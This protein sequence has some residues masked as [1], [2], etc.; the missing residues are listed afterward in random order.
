[1]MSLC[2]FVC[3]KTKARGSLWTKTRFGKLALKYMPVFF[4]PMRSTAED[5]TYASTSHSPIADPSP[6][7]TEVT[8]LMRTRF[9]CGLSSSVAKKY[10]PPDTLFGVPDAVDPAVTWAFRKS[11]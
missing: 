6:P 4:G 11:R 10:D 7:L 1:M 8:L 3:G 2:P 9:W 5:D